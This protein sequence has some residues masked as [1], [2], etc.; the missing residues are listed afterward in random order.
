MSVAISIPVHRACTVHVSRVPDS[1]VLRLQE[2]TCLWI[3]CT[4]VNV[5]YCRER[6][7]H[8]VLKTALNRWFS[9]LSL[10]PRP[11]LCK[12]CSFVVYYSPA[13]STDAGFDWTCV[14]SWTVRMYCYLCLWS[15]CI[16]LCLCGCVKWAHCKSC[17]L[18]TSD[19]R[20]EF[21]GQSCVAFTPSAEEQG[22]KTRQK[23]PG[24]RVLGQDISSTVHKYSCAYGTW[25]LM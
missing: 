11:R 20:E 5:T 21:P 16:C 25:V 7:T 10:S 23:Q 13:N 14:P 9:H 17:A 18:W 22:T 6:W 4:S 24:G 15:V 2:C 8:F 1:T 3:P 12:A 19:L